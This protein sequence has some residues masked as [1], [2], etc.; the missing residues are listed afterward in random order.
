MIER[1]SGNGDG[2][3]TLG[4]HNGEHCGDKRDHRNP[5]IRVFHL[6]EFNRK[7][8]ERVNLVRG[9][10]GF[11]NDQICRRV[12]RSAIRP[13]GEV[14]NHVSGP[15]GLYRDVPDHLKY[16]LARPDCPRRRDGSRR[17]RRLVF[18]RACVS[19]VRRGARNDA[20]RNDGEQRKPSQHTLSHRTTRTDV[21]RTGVSTGSG[22]P[23]MT[24]I[25]TATREMLARK[26]SFIAKTCFV[27]ASHRIIAGHRTRRMLGG[28]PIWMGFPC[29]VARL[30]TRHGM[31]V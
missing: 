31:S 10:L 25:E 21:T 6:E 13:H 2:F 22:Y 29:H 28:Q 11:A 26:A 8:D 3:S 14:G 19:I 23:A 18:V 16:R 9:D 20:E 30:G 7:C 1:K 12:H 17:S 15:I 24:T 5:D 4:R 27:Q